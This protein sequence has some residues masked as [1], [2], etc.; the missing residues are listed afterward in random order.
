MIPAKSGLIQKAL[1][2][3]ASSL[4]PLSISLSFCSPTWQEPSSAFKQLLGQA[5]LWGSCTVV[6]RP[7]TNLCCRGRFYSAQC[8]SAQ[9]SA[10][11]VSWHRALQL[12]PSTSS[13]WRG[14]NAFQEETPCPGSVGVQFVHC[15]R[16]RRVAA[17]GRG[18]MQALE[19]PWEARG[20][21]GV[22]RSTGCRGWCPGEAP[23]CSQQP[24]SPQL[25]AAFSL[26]LLL[27]PACTQG[28][29][30]GGWLSLLLPLHLG[31]AAL[32]GDP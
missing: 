13:C 10:G 24:H 16:S 29:L 21:A 31:G 9:L 30:P 26:A 8:P 28:L 7:Y 18:R 20:E 19:L 23:G 5:W 12:Q 27:P 6:H 3:A 4:E 15:S 11:A 32:A 22:Q 2:A 17:A 1:Q 14:V 25:L